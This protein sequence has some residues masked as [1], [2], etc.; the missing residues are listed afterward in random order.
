MTMWDKKTEKVEEKERTT[1]RGRS[2]GSWS[3]LA[4]SIV[5]KDLLRSASV[6]AA[7]GPVKL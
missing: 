6:K 4:Q 1:A 3:F 2:G 5:V 7:S